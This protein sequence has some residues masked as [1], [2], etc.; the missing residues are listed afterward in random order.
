M[1]AAGLAEGALPPAAPR[2]T[3]WPAPYRY[4][5]GTAASAS[6]SA[7]RLR[8]AFAASWREACERLGRRFGAARPVAFW[9]GGCLR[10]S[11]LGY[12]TRASS[13]SRFP[14]PAAL[15]LRFARRRVGR[16]SGALRRSGRS[17]IGELSGSTRVASA[18]CAFRAAATFARRLLLGLRP[19]LG[20]VSR[21]FAAQMASSGAAAVDALGASAPS[22]RPRPRPP[23]RRRRRRRPGARRRLMPRRVAVA[24][25]LG[26]LG[27]PRRFCFLF[28][29]V[30]VVELFDLL[31]PR[32][33]AGTRGAATRPRARASTVIRAPSKLSSIT[34]S[35]ETP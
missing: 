14:R 17:T 34:T 19:F 12:A 23:R 16:R 3:S 28:L 33:R 20:S 5:R 22:R 31:D 26:A 35:I 6:A 32:D 10:W 15:G 9:A 2:L 8:L 18:F 7:L 13:S 30:L 4:S 27:S 29:F 24:L 11:R 21:L 25:L 1:A